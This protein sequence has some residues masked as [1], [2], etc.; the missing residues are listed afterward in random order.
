MRRFEF[1][2]CSQLSALAS[3]F[4]VQIFSNSAQLTMK[5]RKLLSAILVASLAFIFASPSQAQW[6]TPTNTVPIGRGAGTGFSSAGPGTNNQAFMG[7]TGAAPNF[8]LL[9]GADLPTNGVGNSNLAQMPANTTKC[10]PT[11]ATANAQDCGI[12]RTGEVTVIRSNT[13]GSSTWAA[14]DAYGGTVSCGSSTT[15]CV[16]EAINV[17][18]PYALGTTLLGFDLN[19]IGGDEIAP[20]GSKNG[21]AA[22]VV[23][24]TAAPISFPALQGKR[25]RSGSV[26]YNCGGCTGG[27]VMQFD[28]LEMVNGVFEGMQTVAGSN[29]GGLLFKP[30]HGTPLDAG[31]T[32]VDS[33]LYF[34]T[35]GGQVHFDWSGAGSTGMAA[36]TFEVGEL[37]AAAIT[38]GCAFKID[39][40]A[41]G[42]NVVGN[43]IFIDHLHA[44]GSGSTAMC[45]GTSA[46]AGGQT[47]GGNYYQVNI[48]PDASNTANGVDTWASNDEWHLRFDGMNTGYSLKF[49]AG[50]C[51]N[52]VF[53]TTSQATPIITDNGAC[54]AGA[55]NTIFV[56]GSQVVGK[57]VIGVAPFAPFTNSIFEVRAGT[58]QNFGMTGFA[59]GIL[60]SGVA[61]NVVN[62]AN[63]LNE[64]LEFRASNTAFT[65]GGVCIT[66]NSATGCNGAKGTLFVSSGAAGIVQTLVNTA[67]SCT[68]TPTA[69]SETVSCSSDIIF[70]KNVEDS[71]PALSMLE[72]MRVRSYDVRADGSHL[73]YGTV[74]QEM[75]STHPDMVHADIDGHYTVDQPSPWLLVKAIQ[76]LKADNDNLRTM[77]TRK[78]HDPLIGNEL[79]LPSAR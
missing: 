54:A 15:N 63:S 4:E 21:G 40:I 61:F 65:Q 9:L 52:K 57:W 67:G 28:S 35:L 27:I 18:M 74:A 50:A 68:H 47:F 45:I 33:K 2:A 48:N 3:F 70:K 14:Y 73:P 58:D 13:S 51:N 11:G 17:A 23:N 20:N 77:I 39:S 1:R 38:S 8:R 79:R 55:G 29:P 44:L 64:A 34:K 30:I 43:R 53:L 66:N 78:A 10:N 62:D 19:I 16:Q 71:G 12:P 25:I 46:P 76:E 42:Q 49:E 41:A 75:L 72:T 22:V 37:N 56:N 69:G 31:I 32:I 7:N 5:S 24:V 60:P 59:A 36:T 26:T 6:Q